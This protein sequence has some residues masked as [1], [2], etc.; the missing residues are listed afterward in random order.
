MKVYKKENIR[1]YMFYNKQSN[2]N[3]LQINK[4]IFNLETIS[5]KKIF[6]DSDIIH[7]TNE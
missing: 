3:N 5:S 1:K 6:K 4:L 7:I 2:K